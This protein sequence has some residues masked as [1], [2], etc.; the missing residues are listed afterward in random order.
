[1]T[2]NGAYVA[3]IRVI[4]APGKPSFA[5][6]TSLSKL[7]RH[8]PRV[9]SRLVP[10]EHAEIR[11][12]ETPDVILYV[13]PAIRHSRS[14]IS[15]LS[16][17]KTRVHFEIKSLKCFHFDLL[18]PPLDTC[19]ENALVPLKQV[20]AGSPSCGG[21]VKVCIPGYKLTELAHSFYSRLVVYFFLCGPF[22][23][24]SFLKI[25]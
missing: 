1:M 9:I 2:P 12:A 13:S 21:D 3:H 14:S 20:P 11:R 24:I 6:P 23:Y 25:S 5:Y 4:V 18:Y 15:R 17:M 7:K 22:N 16:K 19:F 8:S 10:A